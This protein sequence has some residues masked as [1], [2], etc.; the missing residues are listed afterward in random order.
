[1]RLSDIQG[2][3]SFDILA[4]LMTPLEGLS[5]DEELKRMIGNSSGFSLAK[6]LLKE[7][8]TEVLE[9]MA[10][11]N[12]TTVDKLE[13]NVLTLPKMVIEIITDPVLLELFQSLSQNRD[14]GAFGSV[15]ENTEE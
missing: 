10:I 13:Y 6:Y 15:T 4:E 1:M 8:K 7:H 11:L 12:E 5:K 2:E 9:V 14:V 3:K